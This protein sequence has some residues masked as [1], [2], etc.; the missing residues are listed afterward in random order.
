MVSQRVKQCEH[1]F[2]P[3]TGLYNHH[4]FTHPVTAHT[5]METLAKAKSK[6]T[7]K[8]FIV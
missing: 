6:Q 3:N 2:Y 7:N 8:I 1:Y 5:T 4:S